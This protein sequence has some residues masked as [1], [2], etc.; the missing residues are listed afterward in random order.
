MLKNG[1]LTS[2][3][4]DFRG[5]IPPPADFSIGRIPRTRDT[6]PTHHVHRFSPRFRLW[7]AARSAYNLQ[8][9]GDA[10]F[11]FAGH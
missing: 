3:Q 2:Q 10:D 8:N 7:F 1:L 11:R 9:T 6:L 5:S 4:E